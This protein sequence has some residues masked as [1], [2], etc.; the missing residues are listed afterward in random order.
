VWLYWP[1]IAPLPLLDSLVWIPM[2]VTPFLFFDD[3]E[4]RWMDGGQQQ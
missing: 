1:H 2:Y 4:E 3:G